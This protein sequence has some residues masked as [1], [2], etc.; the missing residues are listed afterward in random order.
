MT[1]STPQ[2]DRNRPRRWLW[3]ALSLA[4]L[5]AVV[6]VVFDAEDTADV[7]QATTPPPAPPVSVFEVSSQRAQAHVSVFAEVRPRWA[8][9]LR[10]SVSGR[11]IQ[12]FDPALAGA[13]VDKG[14]VLYQIEPAPY[15]ANVA[16]AEQ[17]LAEAELALLQAEN[18]TFVAR[19]QFERDGTQPPNDLALHLPE[20]RIARHAVTAANA[21]LKVARQ[22]LADTKVQAPFSG[23]VTKRLASL[24]ET[25]GPGDALLHLADDR[26]FELTVELTPANWA[27]LHHP[28]AGTTATLRHRDGSNLGQATIRQGG[29]FLDPKTRQIRVFL[30][31]TAPSDQLLAGDFL[32]VEFTGRHIANTLTV[33]ETAL[34]RAGHIWLVENDHLNR[35]APDILFRSDRHITIAA[36]QGAGPWLVAP[37]PLASFLPGQRVTPTLV[38]D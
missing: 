16:N 7:K 38:E 2:P 3:V 23:F 32:R 6:L 33:P 29:G 35:V 8:T 28:I 10:A 11:I 24:G 22:Q 26:Q 9:D 31:V 13:Q 34:T 17:A 4:V 21:Q 36:P 25:V 20:Q 1:N 14:D 18:K 19:R 15:L 30:E 12:V 5:I 37:T 27:L